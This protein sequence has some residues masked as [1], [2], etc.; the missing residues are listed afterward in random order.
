M[1]KIEFSMILLRCIALIFEVVSL[2]A[3]GICVSFLP[4]YS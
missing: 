1:K 2:I 3:R 4:V